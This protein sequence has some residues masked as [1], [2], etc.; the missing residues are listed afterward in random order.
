M[1]SW[2]VLL[3]AMMM[4]ILPLGRPLAATNFIVNSQLDAV[5]AAPNGMCATAVGTCTLRAAVQEASRV[6]APGNDVTIL[7]PAGVYKL[8]LPSPTGT[9]TDTEKTGDLDIKQ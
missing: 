7:I 5:D 6:V 4:A 1:R 2:V 3:S 9:C 8:G